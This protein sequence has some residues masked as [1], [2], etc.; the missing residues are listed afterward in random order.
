MLTTRGLPDTAVAA[1]LEHRRDIEGKSETCF[2][3]IQRFLAGLE[4]KRHLLRLFHGEAEFMIG[5]PTEIFRHKAPKTSYVV[6]L[7]D[8]ATPGYLLKT[9]PNGRV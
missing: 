2:K 3:T 1:H 7:S 5:D 9:P 4:V 8:G 6:T